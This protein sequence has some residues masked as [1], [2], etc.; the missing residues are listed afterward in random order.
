VFQITFK[1]LL[2]NLRLSVT[3]ELI[4]ILNIHA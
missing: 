4:E 2:Y 1:Y 3:T